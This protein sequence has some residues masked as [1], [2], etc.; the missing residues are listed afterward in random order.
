[1]ANVGKKWYTAACIVA[2]LLVVGALTA[3]FYYMPRTTKATEHFAVTDTIFDRT[4][5]TCDVN[6]H[7]I[8]WSTTPA[9]SN[10]VGS[11][12]MGAKNSPDC[13]YQYPGTTVLSK[14]AVIDGDLYVG[15]C[16]LI[17]DQP[18]HKIIATIPEMQNELTK[19]EHQLTENK[20][21]VQE[22]L[23]LKAEHEHNARK[24]NEAPSWT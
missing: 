18:L 22:V 3:V 12:I 24:M 13:R 2:L 10:Y 9:C 6:K 21:A 5:G 15:G 19:Y 16:A 11:K 23:A 8:S 4:H 7:R 20:K 1:M 14:G 17:G